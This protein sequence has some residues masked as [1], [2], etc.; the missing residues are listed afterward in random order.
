MMLALFRILEAKAG[1]ITVDGI[2]IASIG[3]DDLRSRI[4]I[5]PQ[6]PTLFSGTLRYNLDPTHKHESEELWQALAA[7]HLD[8][9]VRE[10][11]GQLDMAIAENGENLSVGQRQLLCMARALLRKARI[12]VLDEA[13]ASTDVRS[14]AVIQSRLRDLVG[15]TQLTIAHRLNTVMDASRVLVLDKG[16]VR[17]FDTPAALLADPTSAFYSLVHDAAAESGSEAAD[18]AASAPPTAPAAASAA[19]AGASVTSVPAADGSAAEVAAAP[20]AAA[21]AAAD[22]DEAAAV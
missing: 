18:A 6:D 8:A 4:A 3:L 14:D 19:A 1:R 12:M 5:I 7:V 20:A 17:E 10:Q 2:D 11:T 22:P 15:V 16:R 13:T 21:P 9:Y